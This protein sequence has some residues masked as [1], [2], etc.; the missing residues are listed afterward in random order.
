MDV[1]S[2]CELEIP[3]VSFQGSP[4][5]PRT[6]SSNYDGAAMNSNMVQKLRQKFIE[7][8]L[9]RCSLHCH[10]DN[11]SKELKNNSVL[12]C[13]WLHAC[14]FNTLQCHSHEEIDEA[15]SALAGHTAFIDSIQR[16]LSKAPDPQSQ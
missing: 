1:A 14:S 10:G 6:R 3:R 5:G 15:F 4:S 7:L 16:W 8:D 12:G 13:R 2:R 11:A 9:R